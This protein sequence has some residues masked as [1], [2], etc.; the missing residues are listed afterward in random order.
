MPLSS[1]PIRIVAIGCLLACLGGAS[2]RAQEMNSTQQPSIN[3]LVQLVQESPP[4]LDIERSAET[5]WGRPRCL[6][7]KNH[8]EADLCQQ[9]R[10]AKAAEQTMVLNGAQVATGLITLLGLAFTIY[11]ARRAARAA[12]SAA[13]HAEAGASGAL[14]SAQSDREANSMMRRHAEL[15]LRA[16]LLIKRA[17][18][19][20]VEVGKRPR[21]RV[22]F[23]NFGRT[24]ALNATHWIE[25]NLR[26]FPATEPFDMSDP[27]PLP[28]LFV[29]AGGNIMA[30]DVSMDALTQSQFEDLKSGKLA[31]YATGRTRYNDVFNNSWLTEYCLFIGG[32]I[33]IDQ[34]M[35]A[36]AEGQQ[37][38]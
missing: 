35:V 1:C 4:T 6:D 23:Q 7:P 37:A 19:F 5:N 24:P 33:G 2:I 31:F 25:V 8:D 32:P 14:S 38:T 9:V 12:I 21:A 22:Q 26:S 3:N 36:Y 29:G 16:H 17:K 13:K 20:D 34:D 18:V 30:T 28:E 15:E 11:Y 27:E 10:M